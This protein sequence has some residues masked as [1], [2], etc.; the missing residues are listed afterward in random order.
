MGLDKQ[1]KDERKTPLKGELKIA[2]NFMTIW[3]FNGYLK[4]S[5]LFYG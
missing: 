1:I 2:G 4:Y 5:P 3:E